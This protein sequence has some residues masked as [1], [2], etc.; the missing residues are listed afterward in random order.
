MKTQQVCAV[1]MDDIV[2]EHR[3]KMYGAYV[4]RSMYNKHLNRALLLAITILFAGLAY[5]L[6]SVYL[7]PEPAKFITNEGE[8]E[9]MK[10]VKPLDEIPSVPL[11]PP[12]VAPENKIKFFVPVITIDE[13]AEGDA[14]PSQDE[15]G[16]NLVNAP[17]NTNVEMPVEKPVEILEVP[18]SKKDI[19]LIVE[20]MPSFPGGDE[21]RM[22]YLSDN[23]EY[24]LQASQTGIHGTVYI[25]FVVDSDGKITD[26]K[27][28]RG[29]GGGCDEEAV[30]VVKSMPQWHPGKQNGKTVKVLYNMSVVF[31]L[32]S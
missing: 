3:N 28:L 18:E 31:R 6:A 16:K 14:F 10:L 7:A 25:Q 8:A 20:E 32:Q 22:R 27:V 4:L 30:R 21:E 5:P 1:Q 13:V 9:F 11:L 2:F 29:I 12:P 15:L 26:V 17:I 19:F 24:P 23:T